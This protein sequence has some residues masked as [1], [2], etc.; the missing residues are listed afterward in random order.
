[1]KAKPFVYMF[2]EISSDVTGFSYYHN[3]DISNVNKLDYKSV[4]LLF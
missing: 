2:D 3:A 4:E 1:M